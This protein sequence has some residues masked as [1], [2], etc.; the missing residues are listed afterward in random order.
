MGSVGG[1]RD[2]RQVLLVDLVDADRPRPT[3][4]KAHLQGTGN[5]IEKVVIGIVTI[6]G[7]RRPFKGRL[8]LLLSAVIPE[9]A[10]SA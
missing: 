3:I 1:R 6:T 8:S 9:I 4:D 7:P 5:E 2:S 10:G